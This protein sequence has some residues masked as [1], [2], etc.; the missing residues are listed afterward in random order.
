MPKRFSSSS[1]INTEHVLHK[2]LSNAAAL[3]GWNG[4]H[5][6]NNLPNTTDSTSWGPY[7]HHITIW[8]VMS[9][10]H[11]EVHPSPLTIHTRIHV[12]PM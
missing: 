6:L 5:V 12:I 3:I 10:L 4:D 7:K 9:H 11:M 2:F 1:Y 8:H